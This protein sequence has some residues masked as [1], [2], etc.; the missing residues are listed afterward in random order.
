MPIFEPVNAWH[1]AEHDL[2]TLVHS[3]DP[4]N[5]S[6]TVGTAPDADF[7]GIDV[8]T[9]LCIRDGILNIAC[10]DRRNDFMAMLAGTVIGVAVSSIVECQ[11]VY[12]QFG[13]EVLCKGIEI[14]L[15]ERGE[16]VRQNQAWRGC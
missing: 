7:V 12:G 8:F 13:R 5:M 10:L 1:L 14:H 11:T 15:L 3:T 16:A 6:A 9:R 4:Q 2:D